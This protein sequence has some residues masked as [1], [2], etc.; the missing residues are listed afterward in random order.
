MAT[1]LNFCSVTMSG[2][3]R[4]GTFKS[5]LFDNVGIAAGIATPSLVVQ[6]LFLLP[7]S[8]AAILNFGSLPS[9][10]NVDQRHPTSADV[11]G[12][13]SKSAIVENLEAAVGI[14]SQSITAQK[15][16]PVPVWWPPS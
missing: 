14:A 15:L 1:I 11:L 13:M 2:N 12:V 3:V 8:L 5:G 10:S 6:K 9:S 16:F 7:V 4:S